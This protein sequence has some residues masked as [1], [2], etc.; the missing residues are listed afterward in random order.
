[1]A[2]ADLGA[3]GTCGLSVARHAHL[4]QHLRLAPGTHAA[5]YGA[6]S[7]ETTLNSLIRILAVAYTRQA[8][9]PA[10]QRQSVIGRINGEIGPFDAAALRPRGGQSDPNS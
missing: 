8:R 7:T 2:L 4:A 1:M 9:E 3:Q 6:L 10:R 5:T